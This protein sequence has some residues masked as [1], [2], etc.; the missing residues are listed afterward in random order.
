MDNDP[1]FRREYMAGTKNAILKAYNSI[2]ELEFEKRIYTSGS[3][4][5]SFLNSGSYVYDILQIMIG[6]VLKYIKL[7][8][9]LESFCSHNGSYSIKCL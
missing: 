6:D 3:I 9:R 1:I 7:Y 5:L 8:E 2:G 4:D